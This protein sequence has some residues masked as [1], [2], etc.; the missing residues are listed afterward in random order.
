MDV[1]AS[2]IIIT[3]MTMFKL[4]DNFVWNM[5]ELIIIKQLS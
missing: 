2:V 1:I 4:I 3:L 5:C